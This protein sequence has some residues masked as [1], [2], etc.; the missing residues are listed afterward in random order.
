[1]FILENTFKHVVC[2][3]VVILSKGD[4]LSTWINLNPSLDK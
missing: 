2:E 4:E 3:M 1:M